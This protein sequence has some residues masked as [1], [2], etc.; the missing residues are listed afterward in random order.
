MTKMASLVLEDGTT[1]AG[2]L[3][4]ADVSVS[5]EVGKSRT[6]SLDSSLTGS[7]RF[8]THLSGVIVFF[9]CLFVALGVICHRVRCH[10]DRSAKNLSG[11]SPATW[12]PAGGDDRRSR[13]EQR[14]ESI[15]LNTNFVL[16]SF[17]SRCFSPTIDT[18]WR[19]V[20]KSSPKK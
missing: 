9:F 16:W 20:R 2:L 13:H 10:G 3:F 11:F 19:L 14:L 7:L 15:L 17:R 6:Q 12:F 8:R 5:G 18:R 4:G 1:F